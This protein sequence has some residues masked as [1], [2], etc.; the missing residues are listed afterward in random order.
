VLRQHE[1]SEKRNV[2]AESAAASVQMTM[3]TPLSQRI[4]DRL[5]EADLNQLTPLQALNLL[6][7]L[8][9]EL[10]DGDNPA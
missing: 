4:V 6:E 3:F 9:R 1:T 5:Q 7:E 10:R 8:Q 2:A